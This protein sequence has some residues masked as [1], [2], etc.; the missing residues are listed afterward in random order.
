M[1]T[2]HWFLAEAAL[3]AWTRQKYLREIQAF[4]EYLDD[5]GEDPATIAELDE[6]ACDYVHLL[7]EQ[8][9]GV[10]KSRAAH[11]QSALG[12]FVPGARGRLHHLGHAVRGWIRLCPAISY[13]PLTWELAVAM[14]LK[15]VR[16]GLIRE[17]AAILLQFDCARRSSELVA[18]RRKDIV[19]EGDPRFPAD[20]KGASISL[21]H[22]KT[23]RDQSVSV[24]HP[25]VIRVLK[26]IT[27]GMA[28]RDLLFHSDSGKWRRSFKRVTISLGLSPRYV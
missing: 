9:N 13:P 16:S 24:E 28:D 25:D 6:N 15:F 21:R 20:F 11:L 17:G 23:G 12:F 18:L 7:F 10:G 3:S 14:A 26:L 8:N 22:T 5:V 4:L 1:S 2:R 27:H 19:F